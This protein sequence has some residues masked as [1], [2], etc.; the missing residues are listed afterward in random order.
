MSGPQ[1]SGVA[2][3]PGLGFAGLDGGVVL[4]CGG[5]CQARLYCTP[6]AEC[7]VEARSSLRPGRRKS[8]SRQETE[9]NDFLGN[10]LHKQFS[11][12]S[13]HTVS[14]LVAEFQRSGLKMERASP[15]PPTM[16]GGDAVGPDNP[17][18]PHSTGELWQWSG[19]SVILEGLVKQQ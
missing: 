8:A 9:C 7:C 17:T 5:E 14:C 4:L 16:R 10:C 2:C 18:P 11:E 15:Q 3:S 13:L 1:V 6:L 12:K 19:N